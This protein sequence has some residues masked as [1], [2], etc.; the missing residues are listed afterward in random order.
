MTDVPY[1]ALRDLAVI[2]PK[3]VAHVPVFRTKGDPAADR[4]TAARKS[5]NTQVS[6]MRAHAADVLSKLGNAG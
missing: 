4:R 3:V 1:P 6:A 5:F 2:S